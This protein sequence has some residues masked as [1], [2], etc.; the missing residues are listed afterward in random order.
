MVVIKNQM[1]IPIIIGKHV[2]VAQV[3]AANRVP[4]VKVRFGTLVNLDE[5]QRIQW[6]SMLIKHRKEILLQQL[7]LSGLEGC[8]SQTAHPLMLL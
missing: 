7:D 5:M 4:P 6:I 3:V 8:L 1:A 2:K